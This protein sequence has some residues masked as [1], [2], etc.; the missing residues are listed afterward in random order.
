MAVEEVSVEAAPLAAGEFGNVEN[1]HREND[2]K[3]R[4]QLWYVR[5]PRDTSWLSLL[6]ALASIAFA[7]SLSAQIPDRPLGYVTDLPELLSDTDRESLEQKLGDFEQ[8]TSTQ[9]FVLIAPDLD[10]QDVFTATFE[11]ASKWGVGQEGQDNGI[12]IALY[13]ADRE[14]RIEVGYGLEG[15]IPDALASQI[16]RNTMVPHMRDGSV[17]LAIDGAIDEL[18]AASKNEYQPSDE[19]PEASSESPGLY[20]IFE[21]GYIPMSVQ[22]AIFVLT[23]V[24]ATIS[25]FYAFVG[26][27]SASFD[28]KTKLFNFRFDAIEFLSEY[29]ATQVVVAIVAGLPTSVLYFIL[30]EFH[31]H[32]YWL[33]MI[34]PGIV[35]GYYVHTM[36]K[37]PSEEREMIR[38]RT[39]NLSAWRKLEK[40]F[41]AGE[42]DELRSYL[43]SR[44]DR[45]QPGFVLRTAYEE[46]EKISQQALK[47]PEQYFLYTEVFARQEIA[48]LMA[49]AAFWDN[50][51]ATFVTEQV[52]RKQADLE[53]RRQKILTAEIYDA[54]AANA[55]LTELNVLLKEPESKLDYSIPAVTLLI[56][57]FLDNPALWSK[58]RMR[59]TYVK[60]RVNRKE[61]SLRS[62]FTKI[63]AQSEKADQL[64]RLNKFYK[65]EISPIRSNPGKFFKRPARTGSGSGYSGRSSYSSSRSSFSSSSGFSGGGGGSFGGGGASG[66]W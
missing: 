45:W 41:D 63:S 55:L 40:K 47:Q 9:I 39:E 64:N 32:A 48:R 17:F 57:S 36:I 61:K 43:H 4:F 6:I 27:I 15:N 54:Q 46:L 7:T 53:S 12:L 14:I 26:G 29:I 60:S 16:I 13:M 23:I 31:I 51:R 65:D 62:R 11:T 19:G 18:I 8:E 2:M 44:L 20:E 59:D 3:F 37:G 50:A 1:T 5:R 28:Q 24:Y 66:S 42:I 58:W 30:E 22:F 35:I 21:A 34:A 38:E 56:E 25:F 33:L 52:D 10:G 49:D